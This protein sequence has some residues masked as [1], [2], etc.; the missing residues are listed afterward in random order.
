MWEICTVLDLELDLD[1]EK[2]L[3][4]KTAYGMNLRDIL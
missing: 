4:I 1:L 3:K 2:R